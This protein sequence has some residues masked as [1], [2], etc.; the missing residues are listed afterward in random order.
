[1]MRDGTPNGYSVLRID[2]N[3]YAIRYKVARRP[4]DYQMNILAPPVVS[5][6]DPKASREVFV[7]VFAGSERTRVEMRVDGDGAWARL[8][9]VAA[10]SPYFVALKRREAET[11]PRPPVPLPPADRST[12]LW[13]GTL[14]AGLAAGVRTLEVRATDMFGQTSR[15]LRLLRV[16]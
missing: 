15:A 10:R 9:H 12:H 8:E 11:R 14:P 4:A 7:N 1:M 3:D 6:S 16:E 13:R 5:S 2:G